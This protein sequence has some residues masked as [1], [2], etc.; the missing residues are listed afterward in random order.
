MFNNY[1]SKKRV[2]LTGHTGFKGSWLALWLSELG[3][4]VHGLSLNAENG[5][6]H[7]ETLDPARF[8]SQQNCDI[9]DFDLLRSAVARIQPDLI[10]H[11]AAQA[12]VRPSYQNPLGTFACNATGTAHLLEAVRIHRVCCPVIVVT[13]DKCY[14]NREWEFAYRE[15]DP[16][17][18]HDV[19][20]MSKAATELVAQA[21]NRSFFRNDSGLG[22]VVTARAGNVIGGGDYAVDRVVPDCIRALELSEPVV[23]RNPRAVRP[24]QH[25]LECLSGYLCLGERLAREGKQSPVASPFNFGPNPSATQSVRCLVEEI[26][27]FWPG[28]WIDG[29]DHEAAHEAALLSLAIDK[30][31]HL[32]NWRPVWNFHEGVRATVEW[33]HRRHVGMMD[34]HGM[35]AFS[36]QQIAKYQEDAARRGLS[37]ARI[38]GKT[39]RP[40]RPCVSLS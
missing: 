35:E 13:S 9:R 27:A 39:P 40:A 31:A 4:D 26:L 17:G 19:Y 18:G 25:L 20:S 3:A 21:W 36:C 29:S 5:P 33:Y 7:H 23:I 6:S 22:P 28:E 38:S 16:L 34:T 12:L 14:E 11:L 1:Y 30:A 32:L 15:N 10:F 8:A 2:L 37:W 24:W